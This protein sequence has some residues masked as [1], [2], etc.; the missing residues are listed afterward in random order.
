MA[1]SIFNAANDDGQSVL[2]FLFMLPIMVGITM[3][4]VRVN[5]AIQIS[6]VNQKYARAQALFLTYHSPIFP[7]L[8][9]QL[10]SQ[11]LQSNQVIMGVADNIPDSDSLDGYIPKPS[12]QILV[13]PNSSVPFV[14]NPNEQESRLRAEVRVKTT[15]ALCSQNNVVS[16]NGEFKAAITENMVENVGFS[17]CRSQLQR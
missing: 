9:F 1:A 7:A 4:M 5:S 15:V 6:I 11:V 14:E 2:E 17:F 16:I 13:R 8:R 3:M 12:K 10:S